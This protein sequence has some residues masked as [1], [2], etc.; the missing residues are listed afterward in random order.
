M[1]IK[2]NNTDSLPRVRFAPSPTGFLH[3]GSARTA[4][5]NYLFAKNQGGKFI[6]RVEDTDIERG[7][8]DFLKKQLKDLKWLGLDWDEG[9]QIDTLKDEGD[10]GPY[11]QSRRGDIYQKYAKELLESGKAYYCFL[12]EEEI[13]HK[14]QKALDKKKPFRVHS[15]YRN[16]DLKVAKEKIAKGDKAT[17]RFKVPEQK[18]NYLLKDIVR[19]E[20]SFPSDMTGDFIL[21]RS[22]GLPVY[23]FSCVVDD[24]LM[25]I[26]HVFR[27]E[28][29][30]ANTLRQLMIFS[31]LNWN[32]PLFGHL[33]L[34]LGEDRKKLSKRQ[35]AVSCE[36]YKNRGYLPSALLNFLALMGWNPKTEKEV[37]N[38]S[39]LIRE[40][41]LKGLNK[42]PGVFDEK[43]LTWINN[44]HIKNLTV[45]ELW[46]TLEPLLATFKLPHLISWRVHAIKS[47]RDSFSTLNSAVELFQLLS[48][49][50]FKLDQ[51]AEEALT[52][53][54]TKKVLN[55]WKTFLE[56][57]QSDIIMAEEFRSVCKD[58]QSK[59][60]VK[61][62]LLFMPLRIAVIGYPQGAELKVMVPLINRSVLLHR[63]NYVLSTL[64]G[65]NK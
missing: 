65:E 25:K 52:W 7:N 35:G 19:G 27:S 6:L 59:T 30:L 46:T 24:H 11:F 14:K 21:L 54:S 32:P 29:H 43:K 49:D 20:V 61:G 50:Y 56:S 23:N 57:H 63:V 31:A 44:Q 39:D 62:K 48:E 10:Y 18:K 1:S 12:T 26:S 40:F 53:P 4:L 55:E 38:L 3:V 51:T 37:F 45:S 8:E 22:S 47:L 15:P 5:I 41:S 60:E 16:E 28:E 17:V 36:E 34:I 42:S 2:K 9:P 64:N 13:K 58:I 33:S